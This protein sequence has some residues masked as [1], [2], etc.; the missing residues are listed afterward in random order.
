MEEERF[1][2]AAN[3]IQAHHQEFTK[4]QLLNFYGFYKQATI[5]SLEIEKNP[6]PSFFRVTEKTKWHAWNALSGM[7]KNDAMKNYVRLLDE[8]KPEWNN[9]PK[10]SALGIV[11]SRPKTI[12]EILIDEADKRIEDFI[13]DGNLEKFRDI[14]NAI[15]NVDE[16]NSLDDNG[17]GIIHWACDRGNHQI[18]ELILSQSNININLLDNEHQ[19][20][21]H[22]ASSCGYEECISL[23]LKYGASKDI[24]DI[25]GNLCSDVAYNDEIKKMLC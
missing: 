20:A 5:G 13:K 9:A 4:D 7:S 15:D 17:M 10:Q 16:L 22:Y 8:V 18:L 24:R 3:F 11:V 12:D 25:D 14:L 23:L 6:K 1:N 19:T 21:L 2:L